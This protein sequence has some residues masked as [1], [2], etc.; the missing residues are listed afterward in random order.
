MN[1]LKTTAV[2]VFTAAILSAAGVAQARNIGSYDLIVP[3]FGG[4][5]YSSTLSKVNSSRG[6]DNN[7]SNGG[8]YTLYTAIYRS[9]RSRVTPKYAL[10]TGARIVIPYKSGQNLPGKGYRLCHQ[11]KLTTAVNVQSRGSWSPDER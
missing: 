4:R 6:V 3:R 5:A 9:S 1:K 7:T 11:T 8:G 2:L 10:P